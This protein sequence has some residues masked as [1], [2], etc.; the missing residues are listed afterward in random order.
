M[1]SHTPTHF[2]PTSVFNSVRPDRPPAHRP[3]YLLPYHSVAL[4]SLPKFLT[5][6]SQ[7]PSPSSLLCSD[8]ITDV[9][10]IRSTRVPGQVE[11]HIMVAKLLVYRCG[12]GFLA[13]WF[14]I[15]ALQKMILIIE[16]IPLKLQCS[17]GF[18]LVSV[19][20]A[21]SNGLRVWCCFFCNL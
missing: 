5:S 20:V 1:Y 9:S 14:E 21:W 17:G 16:I 2:R 8:Q 7:I 4:P 13:P 15:W 19:K 3:S 10:G 6:P 18:V 11:V 12:S